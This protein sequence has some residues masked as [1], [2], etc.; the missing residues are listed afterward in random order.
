[1]VIA[2]IGVLVGLLLP[3]V[4]TA[5]EAGRRTQCLNNL[6][7]LGMAV[8]NFESRRQ[9]YPGAQELLLPQDPA[10]LRLGIQQA[11]QLD[12][13]V[14]GGSRRSDIMERWNST[15]TWH[16]EDPVLTPSLEFIA[17]SELDRPS[18]DKR[19]AATSYVAN[20]GFM[21]R[22]RGPIAASWLE[23]VLSDSSA[24]RLGQRHLPGPHLVPATVGRRLSSA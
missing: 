18:A 11:G 3:A 7:Q 14:V 16:V 4:Q 10:R 13:P 19:R 1:M 12:G 5:R 9:R 22:P 15:P 8:I 2:I 6:K 20:A 23:P 17:L 21:P 24:Q